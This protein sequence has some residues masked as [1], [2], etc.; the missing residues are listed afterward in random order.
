MGAGMLG[1]RSIDSHHVKGIS[2]SDW[3]RTVKD[4]IMKV[5]EKEARTKM[6]TMTK[7]R[8]VKTFERK[9]YIQRSEGIW[10][11]RVK[12]NRNYTSGKMLEEK[13]F[14]HC[15]ILNSAPQSIGA[16]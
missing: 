13:R 6:E 2:K 5:V 14:V 16:Q 4:A 15:A 8:F 3:K 9:T 12:L 10:F 1:I 7:L 11:L